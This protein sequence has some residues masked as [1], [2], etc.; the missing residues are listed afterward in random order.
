M[1]RMNYSE[2]TDGESHSWRGLA[3]GMIGGWVA[4]WVMNRAQA[5]F[6]GASS[7]DD[8][9]EAPHEEEPANVE[10]ARRLSRKVLH[11]E[12]DD[13]EKEIAGEAVHYAFGTGAGA[14]YGRFC[15]RA[16]EYHPRRGLAYGAAVWALAD[17]T[18]V[19]GFLLSRPPGEVQLPKH[20]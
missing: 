10:V 12:L 11:H 9:G 8:Q 13:S 6:Q 18:A 5:A 16:P 17:E 1:N 19:P 15:E 2:H 20:A 14:A 4:S 7:G 3:A